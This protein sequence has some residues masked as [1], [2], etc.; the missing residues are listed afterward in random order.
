MPSL[1]EEGGASL[2]REDEEEAETMQLLGRT[3]HTEGQPWQLLSYPIV[4]YPLL[5]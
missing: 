2:G 1:G 5:P 3:R 4:P